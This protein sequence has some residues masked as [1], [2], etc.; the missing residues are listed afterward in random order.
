[1]VAATLVL[2]CTKP[3]EV[4]V[5]GEVHWLLTAPSIAIIGREVST[6]LTISVLQLMSFISSTFNRQLCCVHVNCIVV[7]CNW[8]CIIVLPQKQ[9]ALESDMDGYKT[10]STVHANFKKVYNLIFQN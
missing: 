8:T 4:S 5:F 10:I 6:N 3:L 7:Y 1:M 2:L 9:P